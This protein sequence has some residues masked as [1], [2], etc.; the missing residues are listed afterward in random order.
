MTTTTLL[1]RKRSAFHPNN[2]LSI[3][4]AAAQAS[5][6]TRAEWESP[7]DF[8]QNG[9]PGL[10]VEIP[11]AAPAQ[12][13]HHHHHHQDA[14]PHHH[15]DEHASKRPRRAEPSS[16]TSVGDIDDPKAIPRCVHTTMA[17]PPAALQQPVVLPVGARAPVPVAVQAAPP[18]APPVASAKMQS[19]VR[20]LQHVSECAS[21]CSNPLCVST[22]NFVAKVVGHMAAMSQKAA[23]DATRCGACQ[24]WTGIVSS[25]TQTCKTASCNVPLCS[26]RKERK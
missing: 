6:S 8:V 1:S 16:P 12:H 15:N 7:P 17:E 22:R 3:S 13:H 21:G 26:Q 10:R 11:P 4:A 2:S 19:V 14:H 9:Y 23:H 18:A 24:L 20:G 25:H 5:S